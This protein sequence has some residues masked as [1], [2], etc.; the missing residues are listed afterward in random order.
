M[1]YY[2]GGWLSSKNNTDGCSW[3]FNFTAV[4]GQNQATVE[5]CDSSTLTTFGYLNRLGKYL[6]CANQR[7]TFVLVLHL[8]YPKWVFFWL[9]MQCQSAAS[10]YWLRPPP[11]RSSCSTH[12]SGVLSYTHVSHLKQLAAPSSILHHWTPLF[13]SWISNCTQRF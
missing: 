13:S 2:R 3:F 12:H 4:W 8:V 10:W 11:S 5:A 1:Y 9:G 6:I 7:K